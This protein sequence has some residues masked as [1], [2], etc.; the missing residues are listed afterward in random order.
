MYAFC[1]QAW[2]IIS[3]HHQT[4]QLRNLHHPVFIL[5]NGVVSRMP[6]VAPEVQSEPVLLSYHVQLPLIRNTVLLWHFYFHDFEETNR[7]LCM[8]SLSVDSA[9]CPFLWIHYLLK[10]VHFRVNPVFHSVLPQLVTLTLSLNDIVCLPSLICKSLS[11]PFVFF[12]YIPN[13]TVQVSQPASVKLL[14]LPL[15]H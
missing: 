9:C 7:L 13:A 3:Y 5:V 6:L 11:F 8:L 12:S 1:K 10:Q 15:K 4:Q 2:F 14:P